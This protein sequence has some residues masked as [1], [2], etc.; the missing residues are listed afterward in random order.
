MEMLEQTVVHTPFWIWVL[1]LILVKRGFSA[2][3]DCRICIQKACILPIIFTFWGLEKI[4]YGFTYTM[5]SFMTYACFMGVGTLAGVALYSTQK[6]FLKDNILFR[7]G[8]FVPLF[9]I[10]TNFSIKYC[11]NVL[12]YIHPHLIQELQFNICYSS[13]SGFSVGLFIGG[14]INILKNKRKYQY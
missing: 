2:T 4:F 13:I 6:F 11:L 9:V 12:M 7:A 10:L 8:S 3:K 1:L 5:T 14:I